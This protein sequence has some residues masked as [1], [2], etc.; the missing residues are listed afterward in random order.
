MVDT[1]FSNRSSSPI[2]VEIGIRSI[3]LCIPFVRWKAAAYQSVGFTASHLEVFAGGGRGN[4]AFY[5]KRVPRILLPS[6]FP[7]YSSISSFPAIVS[8]LLRALSV[9]KPSTCFSS[10]R[11]SSSTGEFA[12]CCFKA[13]RRF[14]GLGQIALKKL[15]Y[16][17]EAE[18]SQPAY[19][20]VSPPQVSRAFAERPRFPRETLS[21]P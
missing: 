10:R 2:S 5:R 12:S 20:P 15:S 17:L 4:R 14:H 8:T 18:L 16:F 6:S 13:S 19:R 3:T 11:N 9:S 7:S 21:H 1:Y